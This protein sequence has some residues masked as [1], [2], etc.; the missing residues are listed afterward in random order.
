MGTISFSAS[1]DIGFD[2]MID[3]SGFDFGS[4]LAQEQCIHD[5]PNTV[6]SKIGEEGK[7]RGDRE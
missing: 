7:G 5:K 4:D 6:H 2:F 1:F 3:H